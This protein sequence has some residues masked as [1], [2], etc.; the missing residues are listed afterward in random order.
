MSARDAGVD[1]R[2]VHICIS[3]YACDPTRGSEPGIGWNLVR[4]LARRHRVWV[5]TRRNNQP[6]ISD[7]LAR[8]PVP[9]L[10]TVYVDLPRPALVWKRGAVGVEVYYRVW[11]RLAARTIRRLHREIGFD[12]AQ[13][14]TFGRYW[15]PPGLASV[16]L[17]FVWGPVGGGETAPR[18]FRAGFGWRGRTYE[19]LRDRARDVGERTPAVRR[20]AERSAL[21]LAVTPDTAARLRAIGAARVE[22]FSAMGFDG[23]SYGELVR[24]RPASA[25]PVRFISMGRLLHWKGV[26]LGLQAFAAADIPESEFW[27]VGEGPEGARLSALARRLRLESRVR[28]LGARPRREALDLL[29]ACHVLVHAS[30]HDSGGWVCLEAMAAARPVIC[31]DLGGPAEQVTERTGM[32]IAAD[33]PEQAVAGLANAMTALGRNPELRHAMGVAAQERVRD[34]YLWERKGDRLDELIASALCSAP[35]D[36][37]TA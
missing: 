1:L 27:I 36:R 12:V 33:T 34:E 6:H 37:A 28:F 4:E 25:G 19:W 10:R 14:I 35:A 15:T 24:L 21:A 26:H 31:L 2:D 8:A 5:V 16:P 30:L 20:A 17:P 29:A 32:K 13:H 18:A 23:S 7:E 22:L 9:N 11:Q 3:A